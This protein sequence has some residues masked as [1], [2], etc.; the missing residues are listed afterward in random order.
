M[1]YPSV[2]FG[3]ILGILCACFAFYK[4]AIPTPLRGIPFVKGSD[5]RMFGDL[6]AALAHEVSYTNQV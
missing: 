6:P 2:T 3:L 1:Y 5:K 4:A